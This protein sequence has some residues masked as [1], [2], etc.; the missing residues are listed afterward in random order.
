MH[1]DHVPTVPP[2]CLL[3]A[4][5]AKCPVHGFILPYPDSASP[6]HRY[7][8]TDVEHTENSPPLPPDADVFRNVHIFTVQGHPEFVE[9]IVSHIIDSREASGR[10][11]P[12]TVSLGR[13]NMGRPH[14]GIGLVGRAIW[15]VL[16]VEPSIH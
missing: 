1:L 14:D 12:D 8:W 4:S 7:P 10:M 13:A 3:L 6:G 9:A 15:R 16:G 11:N 2:G 5:T